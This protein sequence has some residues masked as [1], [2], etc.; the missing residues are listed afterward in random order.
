[1]A[2]TL[3]IEI[4][5]EEIPAG[6]LK[7]AVASF[8]RGINN[9]LIEERI[10]FSNSEKYYTPRRLTVV[11]SGVEDM[12]DIIVRKIKGPPVLAAFKDG[13]PTKAAKGFANEKKV[14]LESL[15]IEDFNGREYVV[16]E[17][18]EETRSLL[19]LF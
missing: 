18:E 2:R 3:L 16:A 7:E 5:T 1:M 15:K 12:Q 8:D 13:K 11:F 6:Y 9:L 10:S 17:V 4:G 14:P 19:I